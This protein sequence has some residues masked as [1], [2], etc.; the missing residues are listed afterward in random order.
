MNQVLVLRMVHPLPP[1]PSL[2]TG[3]LL[4]FLEV[5]FCVHFILKIY[6]LSM[7]DSAPWDRS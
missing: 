4:V 2:R 6:N 1:P 7:R 3:P 5:E